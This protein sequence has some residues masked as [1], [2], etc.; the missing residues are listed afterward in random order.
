MFIPIWN[1]PAWMFSIDE[2]GRA[3]LIDATSKT[4]G[5]A[6]CPNHTIRANSRFIIGRLS[7][8]SLPRLKSQRGG[9]LFSD[10]YYI[11][12][13][14]NVQRCGINEKNRGSHLIPHFQ[15]S[16]QGLRDRTRN[17]ADGNQNISG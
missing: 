9:V 15:R 5:T 10:T 7:V 1:R 11:G 3:S 12:R 8:R 2:G 14:Y 16:P 17:I 13:R 6:V 4:G